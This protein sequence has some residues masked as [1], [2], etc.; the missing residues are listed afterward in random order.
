MERYRDAAATSARGLALPHV[1][2]AAAVLVS[3]VRAGALGNLLDL[4]AALDAIDTAEEC[5]R[6]QGVRTCCC[7]CSGSARSS[8]TSAARRSSAERRRRPA[9]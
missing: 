6:R 5:A 8:T 7:S 1:R 9:S 3:V 2:A 4:D